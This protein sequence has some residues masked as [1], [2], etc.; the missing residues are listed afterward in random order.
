MRK[1]GDSSRL[2]STQINLNAPE[3]NIYNVLNVARKDEGERAWG[4]AG[5]PRL[6]RCGPGLLEH[7]SSIFLFSGIRVLWSRKGK[8]S[9]GERKRDTKP[10]IRPI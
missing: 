6:V 7:S 5:G 9:M 1:R 2:K 8:K 4:Q 3:M 10:K